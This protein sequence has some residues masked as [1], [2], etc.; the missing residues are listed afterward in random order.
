M[1]IQVISTPINA[2]THRDFSARRMTL[3][4]GTLLALILVRQASAA[5]QTRC[6][7]GKQHRAQAS[8]EALR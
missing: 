8:S 2:G 5:C 3:A 1:H 4:L 7:H 6:N